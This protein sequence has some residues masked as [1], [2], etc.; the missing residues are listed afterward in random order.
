MMGGMKYHEI[1]T[2]CSRDM[3]EKVRIR[4]LT[5]YMWMQTAAARHCVP[6]RLTG[7]DMNA[8]GMTWVITHFSVVWERFPGWQEAVTVESWPQSCSGF[9]TRRDYRLLNESGD[10][11]ALGA[12]N[13]CL[14]DLET[15][16]PVPVV[17]ISDRLRLC[18]DDE[19][20]PGW[21]GD[22]IEAVDPETERGEACV[23]QVCYGDLDFNDHC[24]N[25]RYIEWA[26][27]A[28]P[29][30][31]QKEHRPERMDIQFLSEA[32]AGDRIRVETSCS[33]LE[34]LQRLS[35]I[36]GTKEYCRLKT[37]WR[38]RHPGE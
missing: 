28:L 33:D 7:P 10:V 23:R 5:F 20:L 11:I 15:R 35:D 25:T 8:E 27:D 12:S 18:P 21:K 9:K 37:R 13:W 34:T 31:F 30:D 16:K 2:A 29:V 17:R 32:F 3:D 38:P 4:P 14:L 24:T 19:A 6:L 36:N 22:R 1:Q 26:W